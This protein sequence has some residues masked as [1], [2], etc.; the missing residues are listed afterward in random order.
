MNFSFFS[1][2]SAPKKQDDDSEAMIID[3]DNSLV[4]PIPLGKYGLPLHCHTSTSSVLRDYHNNPLISGTNFQLSP[5]FGGSDSSGGDGETGSVVSLDDSVPPGLTACDTDAS[6]DSGI[7]E[8]S[9]MDG[10]SGSPRKRLSSTSNSTNQAESAP[11]ALDVETPVTQKSVE[12]E[13]EGCGSGSNA[14]SRKTSISFLDS[15]NPLLHTPAMMD[16]VNDDYIMGEGGF[17]FSDN[18]L[19]QV[20][21]WPEIA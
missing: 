21:G 19:E 4:Q 6:S 13:L 20:L 17:E 16:L 5:V 12:E 1:S 11:P 3:E 14:P 15:S 10:A 7:D 8:N 9:L 18:Q 2:F